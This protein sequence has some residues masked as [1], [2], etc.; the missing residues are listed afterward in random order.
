[1]KASHSNNSMLRK[2]C[3]DFLKHIIIITIYLNN[4]YRCMYLLVDSVISKSVA[5]DILK[6]ERGP[7]RLSMQGAQILVLLVLSFEPLC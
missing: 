1:M 7:L 3:A 2:V 5:V 4:L 6:G